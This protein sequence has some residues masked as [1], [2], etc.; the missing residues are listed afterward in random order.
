LV[1]PS[2]PGEA[3]VSEKARQRLTAIA[4][5]SLGDEMRKYG[6]NAQH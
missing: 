2:L 1:G 6:T 4:K 5:D 3:E